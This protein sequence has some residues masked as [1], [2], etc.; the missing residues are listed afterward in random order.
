[1][2]QDD[3]KQGAD[4]KR[5]GVSRSN[6]LKKRIYAHSSSP[7]LD[8]SAVA[9]FMPFSL[10]RERQ[11]AAIS[12]KLLSAKWAVVSFRGE[13]MTGNRLKLVAESG[14]LTA[15][16]EFVEKERRLRGV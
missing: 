10:A 16:L 2:V 3:Q 6:H 5:N 8:S 7:K 1:M 12:A 15:E 13:C 4:G 14:V 9:T 11:F